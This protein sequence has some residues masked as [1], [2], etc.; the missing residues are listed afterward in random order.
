M[1]TTAALLPAAPE[2]SE[3]RRRLF[4]TAIVLFGERG[5]HGVSVRDLMGALG[6]QP[7]ALYGHVAS[8]QQLLYEL[9]RLGY[10]EHNRWVRDAL[11]SAGSDPVDQMRALTR[12]HVLAHLTYPALAKV[13]NR[14]ARALDPEQLEELTA[15]LHD[16]ERVFLDVMERGQRLGVFHVDDPVLALAAIAAMGVRA[17]ESRTIDP[18]YS[19]ERVA[20]TY[21][22]YA[23]K[24]LT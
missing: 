3:A 6:Q 13:T 17:A 10:T 12:A 11:L 5:V 8:K 19:P 4:E 18:T 14:E 22:G 9:V 7:G 21:A 1:T 16:S 15:I 20:D 23:V 24:I 2:W